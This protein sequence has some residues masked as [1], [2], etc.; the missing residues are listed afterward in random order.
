MQEL[1]QLE[2]ITMKAVVDVRNKVIQQQEN[3]DE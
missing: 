2:E 3:E 1:E